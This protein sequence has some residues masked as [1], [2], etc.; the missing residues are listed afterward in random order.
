MDI[1]GKTALSRVITR[2]SRSRRIDEI[3]V[4]TTTATQDDAIVTRAMRIGVKWFRGSEN[5]VLSRYRGAAEAFRADLVVR[6]TSD[7]P[8]IDPAVVDQVIEKCVSDKADFACNVLPRSFPR[9]LDTEVFSLTALAKTEKL[10]HESYQREHVTPVFYERRD[11][12]RIVSVSAE[13]DYSR[14]RWTLDTPEDLELIHAI[15]SH[16]N[17]NDDFSWRE[18]LALM[19]RLPHLEGI[20]AHI[21]QKPVRSHALVY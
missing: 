7:C 4:A 17:N 1:G 3:V 2:L 12:F 15:Y 21:V 10:A 20:N 18:V 8:L 11:L 19:D 9:G 13:R 5:D 16:F 6:I 14:Y